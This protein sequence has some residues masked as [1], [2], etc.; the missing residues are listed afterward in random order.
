MVTTEN[1]LVKPQLK[2]VVDDSCEDRDMFTRVNAGSFANSCICVFHFF[3][4]E[5]STFVP[6]L[7]IVCFRREPSS[8]QTS[9]VTLIIIIIIIIFGQGSNLLWTHT[10]R[11][12][13]AGLLR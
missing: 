8:L 7:I 3:S 13:I 11:P 12:F 4:S 10:L 6:N 2:A 9:T 1:R 5:R